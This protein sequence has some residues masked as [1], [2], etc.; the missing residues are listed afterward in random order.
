MKCAQP[1]YSRQLSAPPPPW[2]RARPPL[3]LVAIRPCVAGPAGRCAACD[4]PAGEACRQPG[5]RR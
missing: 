5:L 2:G 4:A 3:R 1:I